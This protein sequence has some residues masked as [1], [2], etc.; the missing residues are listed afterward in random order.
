MLVFEDVSSGVNGPWRIKIDK[1]I[2]STFK[3]PDTITVTKV[4]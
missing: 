2:Y 3:S 1:K 4:C